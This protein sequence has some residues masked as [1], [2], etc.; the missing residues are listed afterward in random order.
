MTVYDPVR[1]SFHGGSDVMNHD[2]LFE[3]VARINRLT[4][5]TIERQMT[6][7]DVHTRT[8]RGSNDG[9]SLYDTDL[10]RRTSSQREE[11]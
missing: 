9:M 3:A 6:D 10:L 5:V 7:E 2:D 1:A 4:S 8:D 11:R